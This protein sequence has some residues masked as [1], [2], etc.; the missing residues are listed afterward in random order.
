MT[1][2]GFLLNNQLTDFSAAPADATGAPIANRVAPLKRPRSSMAPTLVFRTR[3]DG[4]R[5][6]FRMATGSPGGATIIQYVTKVLVGFVDWEL[7]AQQATSMVAF[8]AANTPTTN[9]GGE[10]P[11]VNLADGGA[12]DALIT[13]LRALGHTVGTGAQSSGIGTIVRRSNP[14]GFFYLEGGAD[15]RREGVVLGDLY[16]NN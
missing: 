14:Q 9:V 16:P 8:G 7:D 12:S 6:E 3:D 10:H 15:P 2:G 11:N 13:G 4:S 1:R 5:G